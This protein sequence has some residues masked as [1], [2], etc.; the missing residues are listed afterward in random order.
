[1]NSHPIHINPAHAGRLHRKLFVPKGHKIPVAKLEAAKNS[2]NPATRKQ[3]N[4]ALNARG[5]NHG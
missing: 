4:F 1:M 2:P 3:A 5:W